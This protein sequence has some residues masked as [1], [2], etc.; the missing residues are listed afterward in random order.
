MKRFRAL[1]HPLHTPL[2]HF[3]LALWTAGFLGDLLCLWRSE[4]FW[5]HFAFWNIA[6]GL[7]IGCL[8]LLTGFY[9]FLFVPEDNPVAAKTATWHMMVMLTAA[10]FFGVSLYFH[11]G[12]EALMSARLTPALILS[13]VGTL[14]LQAGGWLGGQLV[15]RHRIGYDD[16]Y[17]KVEGR[18]P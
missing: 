13:G 9:D 12:G 5:W 8:T 10:C 15:Y 4:V 6:L 1:G 17:P 2:T 11:S 18:K 14:C 16:G 7:V 3:P